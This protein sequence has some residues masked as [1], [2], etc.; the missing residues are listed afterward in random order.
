MNYIEKS[1]VEI[2]KRHE[3]FRIQFILNTKKE[4]E[5]KKEGETQLFIKN[6][7]LNENSFIL[8]ITNI[9]QL[10]YGDSNKIYKK[11]K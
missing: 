11:W 10:L 3:V 2:I 7:Y 9:Q 6:E 5:N 8:S 4:K 1:I